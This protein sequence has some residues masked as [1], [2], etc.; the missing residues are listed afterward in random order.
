MIKNLPKEYKKMDKGIP[1]KTFKEIIER[2]SNEKSLKIAN[3]I[4]KEIVERI[5]E[6][7]E[8]P[9]RQIRWNF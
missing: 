4:S 2:I 3:G 8:F 1:N 6:I 5:P 7:S 9:F